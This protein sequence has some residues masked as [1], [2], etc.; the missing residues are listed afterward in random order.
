MAVEWVQ[1]NIK[2]F[3]GDPNR[4]TIF[5]QSS[6]SVAV[7]FWAYAYRSNPIVAGMIS[8]SGDVF[9]FPINTPDLST[10]N[11]YNAS[12]ILGCGSTGDVM[13]CMRAQ[14]TSAILSAAAKV[15]P[16]PASSQARSQPAFQPVI[17]NV[18]VF[19]D[20]YDRSVAGNFAKIV[21]SSLSIH[22]NFFQ[23]TGTGHDEEREADM[24]TSPTC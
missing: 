13:A 22:S 6:G 23:A 21:S 3:G 18:I 19:S 4:I 1:N 15:L 8:H 16:P 5:G 14:N 9:S 12:A 20:Y 2:S 24:S 7:D 17:D 11:W 10:K